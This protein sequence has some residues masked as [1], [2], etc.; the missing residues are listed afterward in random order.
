VTSSDADFMAIADV[1]QKRRKPRRAGRRDATARSSRSDAE[2]DV[3]ALADAI[4]RGRTAAGGATEPAD[5]Q[6]YT[7]QPGPA[8]GALPERFTSS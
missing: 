1:L 4:Q 7:H 5:R 2:D 3:M 6:R 8:G